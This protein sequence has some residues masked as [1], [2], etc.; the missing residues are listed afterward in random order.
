MTPTKV[1]SSAQYQSQWLA[2][3]KTRNHAGLVRTA[4][5]VAARVSLR[6]S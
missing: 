5:A 3:Q 2:F 1:A 4:T 6:H